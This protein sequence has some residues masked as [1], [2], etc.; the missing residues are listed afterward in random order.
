[1]RFI[2]ED[3]YV[4]NINLFKEELTADE[5]AAALSNGGL[6]IASIWYTN[7]EYAQCI[8]DIFGNIKNNSPV[9]TYTYSSKDVSK[10]K[11]SPAVPGA[12]GE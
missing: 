9:K 10:L 11:A 8:S 6:P 5:I 4:K 12:Q 1:M 3:N 2:D 7:S